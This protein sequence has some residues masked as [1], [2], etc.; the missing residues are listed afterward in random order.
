MA[1]S[2]E[3]IELSRLLDSRFATE[4]VSLDDRGSQSHS[5]TT[6]LYP[7]DRTTIES[8]QNLE[9]SDANDDNNHA[10]S[11]AKGHDIS[12]H[13]LAGEENSDYH[14]TYHAPWALRRLHLLCLVVVLV[15]MIIALEVTQYISNK[16]QG[17]AT[18]T[19]RIHYLWTYGPTAVFSVL[20]IFWGA[21]EYQ[22]KVM[23]PW[24]LMVGS[25]VS[26]TANVSVFLSNLDC[27]PGHVANV[28]MLAQ[29]DNWQL[30]ANLSDSVC[31]TN[32][33]D[34]GTRYDTGNATVDGSWK[35]V[36]AASLQRC[37]E[38]ANFDSGSLVLT[39]A[40]AIKPKKKPPA[41]YDKG[42]T[43]QLPMGSFEFNA[44]VL[45]C[46]PTNNMEKALVT[47]NSSDAILDVADGYSTSRLNLSSWDMALAFNNTVSSASK[48]FTNRDDLNLAAGMAPYDTYFKILQA[49]S[50][51]AEA[52]YLDSEI[53]EADSRRLVTAVWAQ[54]A[55]QHL[56]SNAA[57]GDTGTYRTSLP[58]C[59]SSVRFGRWAV[60]SVS[61][62]TLLSPFL[63]IIVSGLF[64]ERPVPQ[65]QTLSTNAVDN[66][67]RFDDSTYQDCEQLG[68]DQATLNAANLLI[69]DVIPF[70]EG[71]FD[72]YIYPLMTDISGNTSMTGVFN[73]SSFSAVTPGY[74]PHTVCQA[75]D[76]SQ[77]QYTL[78]SDGSN[79]GP[80]WPTKPYN[81]YLNFTH[82]DL[83]GCD[84]SAP[85]FPDTYCAASELLSLGMELSPNNT[86]FQET[87]DIGYAFPVGWMSPEGWPNSSALVHSHRQCPNMTMIYGDWDSRSNSSLD[88]RG[89]ACY[90]NMEQ[91]QLNTSYAFP[92]QS[93]TGVYP[94][95]PSS[96]VQ[97][98]PSCWPFS[99]Y[100]INDYLANNASA[101]YDSL[102]MAASNGSDEQTLFT[103]Y[104][105]DAFAS[106]IGQIYNTF[107]A[108]YFSLNLRNTNFT[109][110]VPQVPMTL[111]DNHRQ[112]LFPKPAFYKYSRRAAWHHLGM[113]SDC[114]CPFDSKE[115]LPKDPC[116][117]AAQAS[118]FAD[119]EFIDLIPPGAES[120]SDEK[121]AETTPF[122][123][124][125][126]SLG[127]WEK[128]GG[129]KRTFGVDVGQAVSMGQGDT[130]WTR[131]KRLLGV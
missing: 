66:L 42:K 36:G 97:A 57:K 27:H 25:Q 94:V 23:M 86:I 16:N 4:E 72:N 39:F 62:S 129:E 107:L 31:T 61:L 51:G 19:Q 5:A 67:T 91:A 28:T 124:H 123:D 103:P 44:T 106:R 47:T 53:L 8:I 120:L 113:H 83:T 75:M 114:A 115:L 7:A 15:L 54:I 71:T 73:A 41:F 10:S 56:L 130:R 30:V 85:Q 14:R 93:V 116:S 127:W 90:Y 81:Y 9:L 33:V 26:K 78:S 11:I 18:T 49:I 12:V 34:I 88:L 55:N 45:F 95:E 84:C 108:Q 74:H 125:L 13:P 82:P 60:L 17:L 68:W 131:I 59:L 87:M 43:E 35:T 32:L 121:L 63:T 122:K 64:E 52:K 109:A 92:Q 40:Q 21:L 77:F 20:A 105:A 2:E 102:F 110:G 29:D 119:S 99:L 37:Q 1:V 98:D 117:I 96:L 89:V 128:E 80:N 6:S 24:K 104:N 126:F 70:P 100:S 46:K 112:R 118:L 48:S 111:V 79:N 22:T 65:Y 76:P 50:P 101:S 3:V 69:Q 38:S 58:R